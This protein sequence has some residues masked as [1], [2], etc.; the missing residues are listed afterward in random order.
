M[1]LECAR[2]IGKKI[3]CCLEDSWPGPLTLCTTTAI[4]T[5]SVRGSYGAIKGPGMM[6]FQD[7]VGKGLQVQ[8]TAPCKRIQ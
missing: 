3:C 1:G 8:T 6:Q 2:V 7:A 4:M 5:M